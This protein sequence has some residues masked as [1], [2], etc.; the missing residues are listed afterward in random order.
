MNFDKRRALAY[1]EKAILRVKQND[2]RHAYAELAFVED[3]LEKAMVIA[4][5]HNY[6]ELSV[7]RNTPKNRRSF[8][9]KVRKKRTVI[10]KRK[11]GVTQKYHKKKP[12]WMFR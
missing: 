7:L 9:S 2:F 11:D 1:L 6:E 8:N 3:S 5:P 10:K 12:P 4:K